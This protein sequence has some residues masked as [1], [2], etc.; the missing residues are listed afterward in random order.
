MQVGLISASCICI[1]SLCRHIYYETF[2]AGRSRQNTRSCR[3]FTFHYQCAALGEN[4]QPVPQL[5]QSH[6]YFFNQISAP[7]PDKPRPCFSQ[8]LLSEGQALDESHFFYL[9]ISSINNVQTLSQMSAG[10]LFLW[11]AMRGSELQL[12]RSQ[13]IPG[14]QKCHRSQGERD[15]AKI[16]QPGNGKMHKTELHCPAEPLD[17]R[18]TK[19]YCKYCTCEWGQC[20]GLY[21]VHHW[22]LSEQVKQT[23]F[24]SCTN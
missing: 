4:P 7:V 2:T 13:R 6:S 15:K 11:W 23:S 19:I 10:S 14:G 5:T 17:Y 22:E 1:F 21:R 9:S 16:T 18:R 12:S 20:W 3:S 8:S 24:R